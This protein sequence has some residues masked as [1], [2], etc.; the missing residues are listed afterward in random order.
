MTIR[1]GYVGEAIGLGVLAWSKRH[2]FDVG[3]FEQQQSRQSVQSFEQTMSH[4][5]DRV[6]QTCA[7]RQAGGHD[8]AQKGQAGA[9]QRS[10]ECLGQFLGAAARGIKRG[11]RFG[12]VTRKIFHAQQNQIDTALGAGHRR[13]GCQQ[14]LEDLMI[15]TELRLKTNAR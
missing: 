7:C 6:P 13:V 8:T 10:F 9:L 5:L 11:W 15:R 12:M 3:I 1:I 4:A 2:A 14:A